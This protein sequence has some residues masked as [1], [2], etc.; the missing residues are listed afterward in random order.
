[1][2]CD[3]AF[4]E[5]PKRRRELWRCCENSL[6]NGAFE[7]VAHLGCAV[8]GQLFRRWVGILAHTPHQKAKKR[9]VLRD[10]SSDL[11]REPFL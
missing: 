11:A 7:S 5:T 2:T 10:G 9:S 6:G 1:M 8:A 3:G 4:D